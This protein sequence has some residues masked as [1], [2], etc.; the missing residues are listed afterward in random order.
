MSHVKTHI[1]L[2]MWL[3]PISMIMLQ[4]Y[5]LLIKTPNKTDKKLKKY[6]YTTALCLFETP[7]HH[8]EEFV[9]GQGVEIG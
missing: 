7:F 1:I 2:Q 3:Q 9:G 5:R 6:R 8:R 4:R